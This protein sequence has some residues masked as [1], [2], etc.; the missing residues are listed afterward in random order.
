[1]YIECVNFRSSKIVCKIDNIQVNLTNN[2]GKCYANLELHKGKHLVTVANRSLFSTP[3]CYLN[4][5]NPVFY[6]CQLRFL[7]HK[8]LENHNPF[9]LTKIIFNITDEN[10]SRIIFNSSTSKD[11]DNIKSYGIDIIYI[12]KDNVDNLQM[13][14]YK[15]THIFSTLF[16]MVGLSL[17]SFMEGFSNGNIEENVLFC[18]L[19]LLISFFNIKKIAKM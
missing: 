14:R 18:L 9:P 11:V 10:N 8:T 19:I 13:K 1:M 17:L 12:E 3:F 2:H 6:I 7:E 4:I 16:Y 15:I 5:I